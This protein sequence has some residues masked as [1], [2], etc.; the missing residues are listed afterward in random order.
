M[1]KLIFFSKASTPQRG[2]VRRL[3][4]EYMPFSSATQLTPPHASLTL[5]LAPSEAKNL[6]IASPMP[7]V[8]PVTKFTLSFKCVPERE[9][10]LFTV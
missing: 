5:T 8:K 3:I 10:D 7:T 2:T 4:Y 6:T 1:V 9:V